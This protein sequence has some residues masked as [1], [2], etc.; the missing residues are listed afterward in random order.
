MNRIVGKLVLNMSKQQVPHGHETNARGPL[1]PPRRDNFG[2]QIRVGAIMV[3]V[4]GPLHVGLEL[5]P[6]ESRHDTNKG[7]VLVRLEA[8]VIFVRKEL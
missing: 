4:K 7:R 6:N 8:K 1:H 2:V 3:V 5:V